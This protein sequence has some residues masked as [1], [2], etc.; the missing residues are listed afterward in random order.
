MKQ[1][2]SLFQLVMVLLFT[3]NTFNCQAQCLKA[4]GGI[5]IDNSGYAISSDASGNC[6]ITGLFQG[7]ANFS[8][9][10]LISNGDDDIFIAKYDHNCNF[11]W[12]QQLGGTHNDEGRAICTDAV[13]N[14][15]ITGYADGGNMFVAKFDAN[16][17]YI[18]GANGVGP[19]YVAGNGICLDGLG[20]IYVV[21][22]YKGS[23][24]FGTHTLTSTG[25]Y[26]LFIAKY[27]TSGNCLWAINGGS[28]DIAYGTAITYLSGNLY[29]TGG[30]TS[31]LTLGSTTVTSNGDKDIFTAKYNLSGNPQW[32][33]SAGGV[34]LDQGNAITTDGVGKV[35]V[36][37]MFSN[38]ATFG[39]T[40]K[41]SNG[42]YDEFVMKYD[43]SGNLFNVYQY[44][45]SDN[46]YGTGIV[47]NS[48]G[49][50]YLAGNYV[51]NTTF[52]DY[53]ANGVCLDNSNNI[54]YTGQYSG[55]A[56]TFYVFLDKEQDSHTGVKTIKIENGISI[57]P[58][59]V[60]QNLQIAW[61]NAPVN[62][63]STI[64]LI[65][66]FGQTV[67]TI[68][69]IWQ[70]PSKKIDMAGFTPGIYFV[71]I[72]NKDGILIYS[73]QITKL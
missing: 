72:Q 34:T 31:S 39:S 56:Y 10:T 37:G 16:G 29:M 46:E 6:Y 65:N 62:Q 13:G 49:Y 61:E 17:N 53:F 24:Q 42:G 19:T 60:N 73:Q 35:Y 8:T 41:T 38:N 59:P 30:F 27:D 58:N 11:V 18:W 25:T 1:I 71:R 48:S 9:T 51:V 7:T 23:A 12:V 64:T 26:D 36:T 69:D 70:S 20:N 32:V 68:T 33:K 28:S 66:M 54:C 2:H 40:V 15:Y 5:R 67:R 21:G 3:S 45:T 52:Q 44:G 63:L 55:P 22:D 14:S 47:V 4:D 50:I 57:Y 43:V